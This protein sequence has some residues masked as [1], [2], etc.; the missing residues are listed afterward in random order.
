M[1]AWVTG[2]HVG[3]GNHAIAL[4]CIQCGRVL[5][6]FNSDTLHFVVKL[7]VLMSVQLYIWL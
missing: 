7:R 2:T 5:G 1:L 4:F 6:F 3:A